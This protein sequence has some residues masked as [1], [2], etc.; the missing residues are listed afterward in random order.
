MLYPL[1]W[2]SKTHTAPVHLTV[3]DMSLEELSNMLS[4][5]FFVLC[6]DSRVWQSLPGHERD[7]P[8][9]FPPEWRGRSLSHFWGKDL[10]R[11]LPLPGGSL[12]DHQAPQGVLHGGGRRGT[13]GQDESAE[14]TE[15]QV[16]GR[17]AAWV[18]SGQVTRLLTSLPGFVMNGRTRAAVRAP[19]LPTPYCCYW[20][21]MEW[22]LPH[23]RYSWKH[24]AVSPPPK[25]NCS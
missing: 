15:I 7:Y 16:E 23:R 17:D 20:I 14:G 13:E 5:L 25:H 8:P 12:Q 1:L 24:R 22:L 21:I 6:S 3:K 2:Y 19:G 10:R 4:T 9:V 11:H 18:D